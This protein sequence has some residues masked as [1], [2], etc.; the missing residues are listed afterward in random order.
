LTE[1]QLEQ[2]IIEGYR[3][4]NIIT[5]AQVTVTV[6]EA[7][8]RTFSILGQVARPGQYQI[9]SVGLPHPRRAWCSGEMFRRL[10]WITPT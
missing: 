5:N 7:R 8:A 1:S 6:M 3:R 4:A 9:S 2:E 10:A